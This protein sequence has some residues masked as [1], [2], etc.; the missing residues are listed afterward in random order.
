MVA[1]FGVGSICL[2]NFSLQYNSIGFYQMAKLCIVPCCLVIN[3]FTYGE[4][5]D[6][7][8]IGA[9]TLVLSGVGI[10]TVT[11]LELNFLGSMF[12]LA[13]VLVTAQYQIWQG[14]KQKESGLSSMQLANSVSLFQIFVGFVFA[15][16]FEADKLALEFTPSTSE[17]IWE[18]Y[19]LPGL[20]VVSCL[21]AVSVNVHSF[22]LIG[23]TSA[24]TFQVVGHG[25][26]CLILLSGY[27]SFLQL[28]GNISDLYANLLGV[29]VAL[30]G[31]VLYSNLKIKGAEDRDWCDMYLPKPLLKC[32]L[33]NAGNEYMPV[34][35]VDK[36]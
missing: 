19:H 20:I 3:Y 11:D 18:R 27:W 29:S 26:T 7:K 16:I 25:K 10:A 8:I 23:K 6:R 34:G 17:D 15:M 1:T 28:G 36:V 32:F 33:P 13:A 2:M 4:V 12:G 21:L 5:A 35:S 31:V 24:V 22:A 9:L 14:K 30:F